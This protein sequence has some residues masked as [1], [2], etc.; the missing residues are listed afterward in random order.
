MLDSK[1]VTTSNLFLLCSVAQLNCIC[2][3][4]FSR[5]QFILTGH[6]HHKPKISPHKNEIYIVALW[7]CL[8]DNAVILTYLK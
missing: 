6:V 2:S 3:T 5:S 1:L 7:C 8:I 4:L